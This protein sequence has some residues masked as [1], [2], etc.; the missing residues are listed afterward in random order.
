MSRLAY[1]SALA[2]L[3]ALTFNPSEAMAWGPQGHRVIARV[4]VDRL[5]PAAQAA[6]RD[7]LHEGDTLP[8]VAGWADHEGHEK[9]PR[10][11]PWHFVN[12]PL[13]ADHYD[14]ARDCGRGECVVE[15]IKHYRKVL[16]DRRTS[17]EDRQVAL[18][19]LVHFVSDIHQPLHVGDNRDHGGNDTQV[20]FF[21]QGTSLHRVWDSELIHRIGGDDRVWTARIERRITPESARTWSTGPVEDWANESLKAARLAYRNPGGTGSPMTGGERVEDAYLKMAEPNLIEQMARA[22]VRLANELNAIFR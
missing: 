1:R 18:L 16:A 3:A 8:L 17:R 20:Q 6:I 21:G 22:G 11:G 10:S 7:L 9:Y 2:I 15:K 12:V 5:T 19:F 14:P 4:A 13:S